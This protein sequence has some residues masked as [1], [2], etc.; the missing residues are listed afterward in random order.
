MKKEFDVVTLGELLIDM[1]PGKIGVRIGEVESFT[2]K[3]GG[4]PANVAVAASRL[5]LN[6]AF[7]GKVGEDHFGTYLKGVLDEERVN[8]R[9]L[10]FDPDARTTMAIIA[11]PD[12][13]T[14]EFVFYRNP[15]ADQCLTIDDLDLGLLKSTKILH[16][17]S[18]SLTD[19]PAR[20]ATYEAVRVARKAGA[21]VSYDVNY[22]PSLWKDPAQALTEAATMMKEVNLVKV[23]E[24]EAA[25]LT[26][27]D[28]LD[29]TDLVQVE[30]AALT[31][32]RKGP[33]IVVVTLGAEGSYFQ[34]SNGGAYV[35][36]FKV[37]AIDA[38]GCG[39]AFMA[40]LL[41]KLVGQDD[42]KRNNSPDDIYEFLRYANA[43]GA[44][45][46]LKRGAIP[47]M[48]DRKEVEDFLMKRT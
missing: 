33:E 13:N 27:M 1:F 9:G 14:A 47:A 29:P 44:L 25:L 4:A 31:L 20:S 42:W 11:M 24:E 45:T 18:V 6:T 22:R 10:C 26:G 38:V 39:D 48:P 17:C 28:G 15:G 36:P 40:G 34:I 41:T 21:L 46:S 30:S 2:P 43:V 37:E 23:N 19:E 35:P 3:P 16:I 8:T 32:L 12:E 7:I 5:G